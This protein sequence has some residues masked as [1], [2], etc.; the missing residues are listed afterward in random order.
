MAVVLKHLPFA[1]QRFNFAADPVA[2]VA[3]MLLPVATLLAM[4]S[5]DQRCKHEERERAEVPLLRKLQST[6][7]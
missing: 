1:K 3:I 7:C 6:F 2:K 4:P 5:A